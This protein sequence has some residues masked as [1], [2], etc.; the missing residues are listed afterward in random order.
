M[1]A[2][3]QQAAPQGQAEGGNEVAKLFQNVGQGLLLIQQY[4][5]QAVPEA[6]ELSQ[7]LMQGYDQLIQVVGQ[8][9]QQPAQGQQSQPMPQEAGAANVQQAM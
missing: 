2:P 4:V 1:A 9:R 5:Q 7:G 6:A 3:D 8:A